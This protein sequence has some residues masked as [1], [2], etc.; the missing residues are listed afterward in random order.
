MQVSTEIEFRLLSSWPVWQHYMAD[1]PR[2][3]LALKYWF[4]VAKI[5]FAS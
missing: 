3:V 1:R 2:H 4:T 5:V